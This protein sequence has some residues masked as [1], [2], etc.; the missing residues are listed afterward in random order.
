M[1]KFIFHEKEKL[2]QL[3]TRLID[4]LAKY[5]RQDFDT[6]TALSQLLD[7]SVQ[8]YHDQGYPA[9]E[10]NSIT[11]KAEL[12]TAMRGIHPLSLEK[13]VTGRHTMQASI[14]FRCLQSLAEMLRQDIAQTENRLQEAKELVG[15]VIIAALQTGLLDGTTLK[16][17]KTQKDLE[18]FWEGIAKDSNIALGQKRL[19][20]TVSRF[21]VLL[22]CEE[23][24]AQ[25]QS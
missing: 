23:A 25:I 13:L 16:K 19:L 24:L 3:N 6:G 9:R 22:L 1:Q 8:V 5:N 15:Q 14:M 2:G 7:E 11:L 20:L 12:N 21:D 18:A 10:N 17:I 4:V